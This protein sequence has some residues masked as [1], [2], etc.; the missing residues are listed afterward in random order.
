M[1]QVMY[2]DC[3]NNVSFLK[4]LFE[5]IQK[6]SDEEINWRISNLEFIPIYKGDFYNG[7]S[8][9]EMEKVYDFQRKALE[10]YVI[11]ISNSIFMEL[12]VNI[13]TIY[14]G[15]FIGNIRGEQ[16]KIK[17]FDGDIIEIE[18]FFENIVVL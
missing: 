18:G 4:E 8:N 13:K 11:N 16:K 15:I 6:L 5:K 12:L 2:E 10:E 1:K 9:Q 3:N 17:I 7:V 14:E